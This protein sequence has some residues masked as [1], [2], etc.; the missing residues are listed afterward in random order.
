MNAKSNLRQSFANALNLRNGDEIE[1]LEYRGIPQ[2]NSLAHMQLVQEI[3]TTFDVM[4]DT[5]DVIGLSSF[6]KALGILS[7][8]GID[9]TA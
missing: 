1:T 6:Q 8:H 7:K 2:W 5:E 4:L 3:E 9:I